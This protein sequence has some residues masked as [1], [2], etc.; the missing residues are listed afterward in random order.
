MRIYSFIIIGIL[1]V[2]G[3]NTTVTLGELDDALTHIQSEITPD[4][5]VAMFLW[6]ISRSDGGWEIS[7]ETTIPAV[8]DSVQSLL[9]QRGWEKHIKYTIVLLPTPDT[10]TFPGSIAIR[11]VVNLRAEPR[12]SSELVSQALMGTPLK[13]L[14]ARGSWLLVQTPDRYISWVDKGSVSLMNRRDFEDY[15]SG[16]MVMVTVPHSRLVDLEEQEILEDLVIG[17][18]LKLVSEEPFHYEIKMPAGEISVISK[19]EAMIIQNRANMPGLPGSLVQH[20]R[21][22]EGMPYLWGGTSIKAMDCSGFTKNI[23]F[24]NGINLPRDANQQMQVGS[25]VD[26]LKDFSLLQPG[27]M[28]F[29]GR[30]GTDST[31][32]YASH[33]GL[34]MGNGT[35]MHSSGNVHISSMEKESRYYDA[36]NLNRYL[37]TK[38]IMD[39]PFQEALSVYRIYRDFIA[40]IIADR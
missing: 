35:F 18:T 13:V 9:I 25:L 5:T 27:D 15:F 39:T 34:W 14:K 2:S 38:R 23:Y 28:V 31:A 7:G 24:L 16:P 21:L 32:E 26:S 22:F 20:A 8:I 37:K 30:Q 36:Y 12:H 4:Q 33:V 1:L 29:F 3:C 11:S 10:E 40:E 17:N 6:E 19:T